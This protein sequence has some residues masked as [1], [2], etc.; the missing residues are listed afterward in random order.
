MTVDNGTEVSAPARVG[1]IGWLGRNV[2]EKTLDLHV[3]SRLLLN[4]APHAH[5]FVFIILTTTARQDPHSWPISKCA[6]NE[7]HGAM[8]NNGGL[9]AGVAR[10]AQSVIDGGRYLK[11]RQQ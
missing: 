7:Q 6:T 4:L 3:E 1:A 8:L 9:K 5:R 11:A 2:Q 10:G